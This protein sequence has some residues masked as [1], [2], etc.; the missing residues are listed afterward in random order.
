MPVDQTAT[1]KV[2]RV[3]S[4]KQSIE[5]NLGKENVVIDIQQMSKDDVNNITY[6]AESAAA[7]DWDLS[8][9]VGWSPDFQDPSTYLD[10]IK[11]SSGEN[12]KTYLGFDSGKI[13]L[14]RHK[15]V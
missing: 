13:M 8:D 10:V 4:L 9:N 14:L 2:Q 15:L 6:F 12:T 7:E 5:K 3:Q 1:N 11:P